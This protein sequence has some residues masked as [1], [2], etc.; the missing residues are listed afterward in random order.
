MLRRIGDAVN[1]DG[2]KQHDR[3]HKSRREKGVLFVHPD[4]EKVREWFQDAEQERHHRE[5][6]DGAH[7]KRPKADQMR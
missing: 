6:G 3:R 2:E 5:K 7:E 4:H 1:G